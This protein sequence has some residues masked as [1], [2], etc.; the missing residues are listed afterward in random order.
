MLP[1]HGATPAIHTLPTYL[2]NRFCKSTTIQQ[3]SHTTKWAAQDTQ[4]RTSQSKLMRSCMRGWAIS[5]QHHSAS[6]TQASPSAPLVRGTR[7]ATVNT[8]D[9]S[10]PS[11]IVHTHYFHGAAQIL[12]VLRGMHV[13]RGNCTL[14]NHYESGEQHDST[15]Q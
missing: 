8:R 10:P 3:F 14:R 4:P 1:R 9:N 12:A 15:T 13:Y 11:P 2:I 6:P 7:C 5:A